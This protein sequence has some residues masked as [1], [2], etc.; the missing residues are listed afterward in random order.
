MAVMADQ[1]TWRGEG[2]IAQTGSDEHRIMYAQ[3]NLASTEKVLVD[4]VHGVNRCVAT[5]QSH[6]QILQASLFRTRATNFGPR[7]WMSGA[8]TCAKLEAQ[9]QVMHKALS[10]AT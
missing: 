3:R 6:Q 9:M 10:T 1:Q 7:H 4:A 2:F 5:L 8:E